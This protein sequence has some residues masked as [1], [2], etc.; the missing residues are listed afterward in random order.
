MEENAADRLDGAPH[1]RERSLLIGHGEA[2]R[3]LLE[4]Y[5]GKRMH[6]AWLISGPQ[7]IGKA[8]L[9]Y[10]FARF[11]L[12]HPDP[13]AIPP[14]VADLAVSPDH[15]VARRIVAGAHPDLLA[16]RRIAEA[17]KDK[18]P[19]DI[20]VGA[21]RDIVRFF[22]STAG[23]GGW[24]ICLVDAA[25]ELNRSSANALL[26]L[27]EE[28]P[29]RS[30]FLIVA[31]MPGRLLPTIRSRCRT[32][33]LAPLTEDEVVQGLASFDTVKVPVEEARDLAR[34]SEGSLRRAL[35]IA[36]GG[37]ASFAAAV[38]AELARLPATDPQALHA[39]GDKLARRDDAMFDLF[40]RAVTDHIH[41]TVR[42]ELGAGARRL[43]PL[44]E[45]WEKIDIAAAQV[46][47][48]NLERKPFV[49]QVFGWLAEAG[50]R[51]T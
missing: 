46:R 25:D 51:R 38:E 14:A 4:A 5:R 10:R 11:V 8:T 40:Q 9:A 39:L 7:G 19:Q 1:P 45:V 6:H 29:P 32:L 42:A 37:Q 3:G 12:A 36:E 43:A 16:L 35:E 50:R 44:S 28:P 30:L 33:T 27:L 26:K 48:F 20:S 2:E 31:H 15:P 49:F 24:R 22:G 21:M 34:R 41:S 13:R 23:E 47:T 18:I 17:G